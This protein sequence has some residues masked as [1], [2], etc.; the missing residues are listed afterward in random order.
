MS[1]KLTGS[2]QGLC[3]SS[4]QDQDDRGATLAEARQKGFAENYS[5]WR[6]S[7]KGS[8]FKLIDVVVFNVISPGTEDVLG[9]VGIIR[10]QVNHESLLES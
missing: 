4:S 3:R 6:T 10:S 2:L 5:A 9:Q 1:S 7:L 8:R